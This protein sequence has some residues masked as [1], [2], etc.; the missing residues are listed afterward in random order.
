MS[1]TSTLSWAQ[2]RQSSFSMTR[3]ESGLLTSETYFRCFDIVL[4][5]RPI[6]SLVVRAELYKADTGTESSGW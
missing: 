2:I 5:L 1:K 6:D 4:A 3:L